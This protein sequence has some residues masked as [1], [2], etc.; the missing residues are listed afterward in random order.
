MVDPLVNPTLSSLE[1]RKNRQQ[2]KLKYADMA[3]QGTN[4]SSIAS[5]RS[6]EGIY[7]SKLGANKSVDEGLSGKSLEYFKYFV[8]K[9]VSRSPC[10]NRGYWLRLHAIRS[11]LESINSSTDKEI[12]VVNLGCGFDPLAFQ[13]LDKENADSQQ[14]L[15]KFSF[16]DIDYSDLL[17]KK[18]QIIQQE[19]E[20]SSIIGFDQA[21]LS[22][23]R[24]ALTCDKYY[25]RPCD[26][27]N[28]KSFDALINSSTDLP[29]LHDPNVVKVFIAEVSLAYMKSE[30]AD[31]IIELCSGLQN[32]H[33]VMLEQLIPQGPY[34]PFSKQMLKH[35]KN[36]DS[37]LQSVTKYQTIESQK[38]RFQSLGFGNVNAGDMLQLWNSV[39]KEMRDKIDS[40]QPF[41]EL[42]EFHLFCHHY[43]ICHSTNDK[44]FEFTSDY[45]FEPQPSLETLEI[46]HSVKI[47]S[48]SSDLKRTF[49]SSVLTDNGSILYHGGCNPN[50]INDTVC[51]SDDL[52]EFTTLEKPSVIPPARTCHTWTNVDGM[53][54]LIG[55]RNAP[56]KPY[57]DTWIYD[58]ELSTWSE[59]SPLPEPRFRHSA[60]AIGNSKILIFGGKT[61]G[62]P[63]IIYN[64]KSNKYEDCTYEGGVTELVSVI[65]PSMS[66]DLESGQ[67]AIIGGMDATSNTLSPVLHLF[68]VDNESNTI[69]SRRAMSHTLLARYGAQCSHISSGKLLVVGGT[70]PDRL[71]N[72]QTS[73]VVVD[74]E[75]SRVDSV[76]IPKDIWEEHAVCLVGT[77]LQRIS[78]TQMVLL[79]G[80]VTC[81]GFG[82]ISN[83][84]LRII[85]A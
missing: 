18:I 13:L 50:R 69:T 22:T 73:I 54:V 17:Q 23:N 7:L 28:T 26:L 75:N 64:A 46:D 79:G 71:F 9:M 41:D 36:N 42:E 2:R 56:H 35:F 11:K 25:T 77:S 72:D 10:I 78:N 74:T 51:I 67:G 19:S 83:S 82:A 45:K 1:N 58:P 38:E 37:P 76:L 84:S 40:I 53:C 21:S 55:G 85:I 6:V 43:I 8:P 81:Y 57:S 60:V 62:S 39:S 4:N 12:M 3:V 44:T 15:E 16:L 61:T 49:G 63:F 29:Q 5:K 47:E 66:Y 70:S 59:G 34:E 14:F 32:T 80:G 27:N 30:L 68:S 48:L 20:L 52:Q 31:R 65:S 33:F 24:D